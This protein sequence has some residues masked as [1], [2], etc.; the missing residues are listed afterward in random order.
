MIIKKEKKIINEEKENID[1]ANYQIIN[2]NENNY[3]SK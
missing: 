3:I 1:E 2:K